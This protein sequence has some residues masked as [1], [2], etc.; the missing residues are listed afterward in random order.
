MPIHDWTRVEAGIYHAFHHR[1]ISAISDVLN[2]GV[3][4]KDYYALPEQ[5][6]AGLGPDVLT[7]QDQR[8]DGGEPAGGGVATA[9]TLQTRPQT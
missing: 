6:A 5:V 4:P 2:A 9:T 8:S 1:W 3:L 7:L